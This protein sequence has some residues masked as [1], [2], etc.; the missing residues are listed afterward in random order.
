MPPIRFGGNS[1]F[2]LNNFLACCGQPLK[3]LMYIE[4]GFRYFHTFDIKSVR[5][6]AAKLLTVDT[7]QSKIFKK[8]TTLAEHIWIPVDITELTKTVLELFGH[9]WRCDRFS[10]KWSKSKILKKI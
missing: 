3:L 10:K 8:L 7:N 4:R 5:Q 1:S 6:R 9:R 2:N